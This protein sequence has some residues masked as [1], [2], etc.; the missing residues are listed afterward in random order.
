MQV[1]GVVTWGP[2]PPS[3]LYVFWGPRCT[4][5]KKLQLATYKQVQQPKK[6]SKKKDTHTHTMPHTQEPKARSNMDLA[7]TE[8]ALSACYVRLS[9]SPFLSDLRFRSAVT[10][11]HMYGVHTYTHML[12]SFCHFRIRYHILSIPWYTC[13]RPVHYYRLS[14]CA[15]LP[16]SGRSVQMRECD[17]KSY[18][19]S[20]LPSLGN[21]PGVM[22]AGK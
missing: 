18:P 5:K 13:I 8:S 21:Y 17:P 14:Q 4:R 2:R 22:L 10:A 11:I 16:V 9:V 15:T 7:S 20:R 1:R 12:S 6:K 3:P 19:R